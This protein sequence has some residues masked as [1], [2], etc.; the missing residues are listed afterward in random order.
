MSDSSIFRSLQRARGLLRKT[1]PVD[2]TSSSGAPFLLV[3]LGNPGRDYR[4]T[5]HNIGFM[6]I[7][8]IASLWGIS[9]SRVQ[10]KAIIGTG[11]LAGRR[12]ILAKPQTFMNLSGEAV[13]PLLKFYKTPLENLLLIHDDLDLPFGTLRLRPGGG[14]G[15]QKG[16]GSIINRLGT[17]NFSRL[18]M[19]IGRPP[20]QM[21]ASNYVLENFLTGEKDLLAR[22]IDRGAEAAKVFVVSGLEIAMNQYNGAVEP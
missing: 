1:E 3:G 14:P 19:G 16:V 7:D 17:Q 21:S 10:N 12:V 5:R 11:N 4:D 13:G 20:G 6:T 2:E 9:M 15:G 22:V 18:R 8:R